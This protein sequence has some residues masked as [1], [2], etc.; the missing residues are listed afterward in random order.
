MLI[1]FFFFENILGLNIVS[2]FNLENITEYMNENNFDQIEDNNMQDSI[3]ED[4]VK[5]ET[6]IE[7]YKYFNICL[8]Y[9]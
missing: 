1:K 7:K 5:S 8:N 2:E 6:I 3:T 4:D 9:S